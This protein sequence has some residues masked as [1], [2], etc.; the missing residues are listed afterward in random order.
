T[1]AGMTL[2]CQM[3]GEAAHVTGYAVCDDEEYF[4]NKVADDVSDWY[5]RYPELVPQGFVFNRDRV[6]VIDEYIGPG[7][8]I[9]SEEIFQAIAMVAQQEGLLLDPVYTGKAFY[10]MLQDIEKGRYAGSE[11]L[12]FVHTGGQFGLFPQRDGFKSSWGN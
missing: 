9:A 5:R 11:N 7:Y 10:G 2:G 6:R 3:L 12:V 4:A 1:Q 8:A